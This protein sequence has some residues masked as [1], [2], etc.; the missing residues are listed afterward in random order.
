MLFFVVGFI[1]VSYYSVDA[2]F[3]RKKRGE[4]REGVWGRWTTG[5]GSEKGVFFFLFKVI[6]ERD[7]E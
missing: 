7:Y 4:K 6:I 3:E 1:C 5:G 2:S